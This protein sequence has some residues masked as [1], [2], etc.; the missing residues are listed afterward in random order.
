[1]TD[2]TLSGNALSLA[3]TPL[4]GA[5]LSWTGSYL[6]AMLAQTVSVTNQIFAGGDGI[7][8]NFKIDRPYGYGAGYG[9]AGGYGSMLIPYQ[10][11]IQAFRPASTGIPYVAGYGTSPGGY[12]TPSRADYASLAQSTN[13]VSDADIYAAIDSVKPIGTIPWVRISS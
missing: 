8:A 6:S 1:M 9:V 13:A 2:Y 5:V 7:T 4:P 11:F 12:S 10:G 3:S